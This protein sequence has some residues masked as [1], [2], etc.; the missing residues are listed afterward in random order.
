[1]RNNELFIKLPNSNTWKDAFTEYGIYLEETAMSNLMT[2]APAKEH[3]ENESD[4]ENGKRVSRDTTDVKKDDRNVT[5]VVHM[6]AA[7]KTE[8]LTRYG[9]FCT[10]ILDKGFFDIKT[11]YQENVV[12][13][14]TYITCSQL[15]V[16]MGGYAKYTLSLNEPDP[17]N[18]GVTDAW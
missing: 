17:T 2:P 14:M 15:S 13:R 3:V 16:Y 9:K 6:D 8:L 12:Y 7:D 18:R 11:K 10:E 4:L 1:M 5:L